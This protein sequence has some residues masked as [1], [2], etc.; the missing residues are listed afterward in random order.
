MLVQNIQDVI[1]CAMVQ[2]LLSGFLHVLGGQVPP[3]LLMASRQCVILDGF[4]A[5]DC[6][7]PSVERCRGHEFIPNLDA[8]SSCQIDGL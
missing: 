1:V 6:G 2:F 3:V 7:V 5:N 8:F 4:D